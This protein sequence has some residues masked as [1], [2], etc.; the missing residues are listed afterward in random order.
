[1]HGAGVNGMPLHAMHIRMH[2]CTY[3]HA[4]MGV[5]VGA[6]VAGHQ[7]PGE[8]KIELIFVPHSAHFSSLIPEAAS[9]SRLGV[10]I[11]PSTSR[12]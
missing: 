1:M 10:W 3:A 7:H 12:L 8:Q 9:E 5:G 4:G 6:C 2:T 11:S